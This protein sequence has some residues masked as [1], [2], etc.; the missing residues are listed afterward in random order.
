MECNDGKC[1]ETRRGVLK[2]SKNTCMKLNEHC[3]NHKIL[4][5]VVIFIMAI[6]VSTAGLI[7]YFWTSENIRSV[8]NCFENTIND[9]NGTINKSAF[10]ICNFDYNDATE[11]ITTPII[12]LHVIVLISTVN[13]STLYQ[14]IKVTRYTN[15]T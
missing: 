2:H 14:K 5:V 12:V 7:E 3:N 4:Y 9:V 8:N 11:R 13:A 15:M 10:M 1:I 6:T